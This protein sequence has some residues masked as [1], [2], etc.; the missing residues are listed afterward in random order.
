MKI[1]FLS[2]QM[3]SVGGV[4]RVISTLSKALYELG[5]ITLL[6]SKSHEKGF[7]I[8]FHGDVKKLKRNEIDRNTKNFL[9][10]LKARKHLVGADVVIDFRTQQ[11][12]DALSVLL[13]EYAKKIKVI[14]TIHNPHVEMY[15][16]E[17]YEKSNEYLKKLHAVICLTSAMEE[18][19]RRKYGLTNTK[20]LANPVSINAIS[21]LAKEPVKAYLPRHYVVCCARLEELKGIDLLLKSFKGSVLEQEGASLLILGE[22]KEKASLEALALQLNISNQVI[23]MGSVNNPHKY[24]SKSLFSILPSRYEAFPCVIQ[25]SLACSVPVVSFD[26]VSG[27]RFMIRHKFNGMLVTPFSRE[28]LK[29]YASNRVVREDDILALRHAMDELYLD[30]KL[31]KTCSGNCLQSVEEF[32]LPNILSEWELLFS[33]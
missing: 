27:P 7:K 18:E 4:Q 33:V 23:F 5:Y 8:P 13:A 19:V 11:S 17:N 9:F 29:N 30:K 2:N 3:D 32:D 10:N 22:G 26:C 31:R 6:L 16:G 25:E 14:H 15:L 12:D 1:V 28:E 24:V 20:V 21:K